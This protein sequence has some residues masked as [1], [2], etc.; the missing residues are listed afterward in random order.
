M[1][2]LSKLFGSSKEKQPNDNDRAFQELWR[3]LE[4]DP[5]YAPAVNDYVEGFRR[6][7]GAD[8]A[9]L[10]G[11]ANLA[12]LPG[13]WRAQLWLGQHAMFHQQPE[14]G[15]A[16]FRECLSKVPHPAPLDVLADI[17]ASLGSAGYFREIEAMVEPVFD[18]K[19]HTIHVGAN[20]MRAHTEMGQF[21][22]ARKILDQLYVVRQPHS[23][24]Q[25]QYWTE[26]LAPAE[27]STSTQG[28]QP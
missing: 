19:M 15:L 22:K 3:S 1:G 24:E 2:F 16:M 6:A 17:S 13:S 11:L 28:D 8:D 9:V 25:L 7:G 5:N 18:A 27:A 26:L 4:D 12:S 14:R 20:L 23:Q 21:D 10:T